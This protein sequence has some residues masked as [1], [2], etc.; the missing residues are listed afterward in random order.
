MRFDPVWRRIKPD[1]YT[2]TLEGRFKAR[3]GRLERLNNWGALGWHYDHATASK[4]A[5]HYGLERNAMAFLDGDPVRDKYRPSFRTAAHVLHWGH[6]PLSY[7]GE[8]AVLRA[9]HVDAAIEGVVHKLL[10]DVTSFGSLT[11]DTDGHDCAAVIRDGSR[12]FEFYRWITAAIVK[13]QWKSV[14]KAIK[15]ASTDKPDEAETKKQLIAALVC[16]EDRGNRVLSLCNQADYVPRDLLQA[17]TAWLTFDI[18]ALWEPNPLGP[19]RARE[20][21]LVAAAQAYL[22]RR[23]FHVHESLLVHTLIARAIAG[24]L[25][26]DKPTG[27]SLL[28]LAEQTDQYWTQSLKT[29]HRNR[30]SDL[31]SQITGS[32][33]LNRWR[34]VGT[35][36]DVALAGPSPF[37]MEDE[38]SGRTGTSRVTY[39]FSSGVSIIV[40]PRSQFDA[41]WAGPGRAFARVHVHREERTGQK[42]TARPALDVVAKVA[43]RVFPGPEL[44]DQVMTWLLGEPVEQRDSALA[45]VLVDVLTGA[46]ADVQRHLGKMLKLRSVE[47]MLQHGLLNSVLSRFVS[48]AGA[49]SIR[50]GFAGV[51]LR[52]PWVALKSAAGRDL[53]TLV[54][55]AAL[56][57]AGISGSRRGY[58]L[59]I[60]V[61]C[62]GLLEQPAPT[63]RFLLLNPTVIGKD[64]LPVQ[65]WDVV[66]LDL[67]PAGTWRFTAVECAVNRTEAKDKEAREK[68]DLIRE[69][70]TSRFSDLSAY[71]TLLATVR[72][73]DL[74]YE[75]A[76]RGWTRV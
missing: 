2:T 48:P 62:D 56:A 9:A 15:D 63:N 47:P 13:K 76:G 45:P 3:L 46:E 38:L 54:R 24:G 20:W 32:Q 65:E 14:F 5:H 31:E 59:E 17:G 39:P 71:R 64:G 67:E 30:V 35:F 11:C 27:A 25:L 75:D 26:A 37:T 61:A 4:L 7:A 36:T 70:V 29:Y 34:H 53:L 41:I 21:S 22:D 72:T 60:A 52:L 69:R 33:L 58:A 10:D 68:L 19:D 8:E 1:S 12:P 43:N 66:L 49:G 50:G 6:L 23:F 18:E 44:G 16:R 42:V 55:N 28:A 57:Q 40:E 51:V 73:G 74:D